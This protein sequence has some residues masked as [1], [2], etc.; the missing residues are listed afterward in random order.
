MIEEATTQYPC[1]LIVFGALGDLSCRK[2]F[3]A[4]YQLERAHLLHKD[5][6][7]IA[8]AREEFSLSA[9]IHVLET[10]IEAFSGE[11]LDEVAWARLVKRMAYRQL[12]LT[13][14]E[15]YER[16]LDCVNPEEHVVISYFAIS[17]SLYAQVCQGLSR[18]GLT[19]QPARVVLEKPIGHD[20]PSSIAINNEVAHFFAEDQIYRIDHYL[21]KETVLNLLVL[22][23]ANAI[24]SSN[25][26]QRVIDKVEITVAE[27][28][29]VE[30]RW[31]YY[32]K[33]GQVRDMLQ[34]HLL[35]IVALVAM[36]PPLSLSAECIRNEKLKVL[37][38]L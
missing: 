29:G 14:T 11:S 13:H 15:E 35:Q 23:F 24:F 33:S 32:D 1:D 2:L 20:L 38:S 34:N 6:R 3:P 30:G 5:T 12:D 10:K 28:V 7:I 4:L 21:G 25:W 26:D 8:C 37:K 27:E 19:T 9:Y 22:R 31:S 36:E 17:P 16:L 18:I